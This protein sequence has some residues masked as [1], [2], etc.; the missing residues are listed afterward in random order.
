MADLVKR[1]LYESAVRGRKEFREAFRKE[2]E[3]ADTFGLALMMIRE[4]CADPR[5][6]AGET[7]M[8]FSNSKATK[9]GY[10]GNVN[11]AGC[12]PDVE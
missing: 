3:R 5:K 8:K 12:D 9:C 6:F 7:L 11:G 2:K 10:L 1:S 4:G